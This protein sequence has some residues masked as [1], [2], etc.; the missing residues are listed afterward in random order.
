M[1][2]HRSLFYKKLFLSYAIPI[3]IKKTKRIKKRSLGFRSCLA[4][5]F[6]KRFVI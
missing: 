1:K 4:N 2:Y 3:H 6:F 5:W